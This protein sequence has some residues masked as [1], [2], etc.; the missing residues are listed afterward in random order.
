MKI[1]IVPQDFHLNHI[2]IAEKFDAKVL[3]PSIARFL[4]AQTFPN[5][6]CIVVS[7]N[8][9]YKI[10]GNIDCM[11]SKKTLKSRKHYGNIRYNG[12]M[13]TIDQIMAM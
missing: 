12:T 10:A 4:V 2:M 1:K 9:A 13:H 8:K 3:T 11:T 6:T 5:R 7:H